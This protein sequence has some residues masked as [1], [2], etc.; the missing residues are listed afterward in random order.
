MLYPVQTSKGRCASENISCD[1]KNCLACCCLLYSN[2]ELLGKTLFSRFILFGVLHRFQHC[3]GH[4][5]IRSWE[6]RGNQY[7]QLVKVLYCKLLINGKQLP[8]FPLEVGAGSDPDIRGGRGECYH[9]ILM[10]VINMLWF[11]SRD[12]IQIF[13][14]DLVLDF[15]IGRHL[16]LFFPQNCLGVFTMRKKYYVMGC[17]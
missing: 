7:I 6:G 14:S 9:P 3:T 2:F 1:N 16:I 15:L 5:K 11:W 4:I 12:G 13:T 8:A 17:K 10:K